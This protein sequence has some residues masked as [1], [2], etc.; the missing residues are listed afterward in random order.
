M[1]DPSGEVGDLSGEVGELRGELGDPKEFSFD[2]TSNVESLSTKALPS[3]LS[4]YVS[5][6]P[7]ALVRFGAEADV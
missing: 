3:K 1:G 5:R 7:A 2:K 4:R 6:A